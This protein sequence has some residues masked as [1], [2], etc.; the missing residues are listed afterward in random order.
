MLE[1]LTVRD[2]MVTDHE[3][4]S[5]E[6]NLGDLY[7]CLI[8]SQYP[9]LPV[10]TKGGRFKGLIT[11]DMV[12]DA[13]RAQGNK[14]G[15]ERSLSKL[16]EAKDLLYRSGFKVPTVLITDPLSVTS[17]VF[18][19]T[20]VVPVLDTEHRVTGLLFSYNVRIAYD[21]EV[22]RRLLFLRKD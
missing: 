1:A 18:D 20:P 19:H 11:A 8:K 9:F 22:G 2:A 13:W 14:V 16:L 12:E 4:V 15:A 5:E 7:A 17:G 10:T 6:E 21:R 3:T